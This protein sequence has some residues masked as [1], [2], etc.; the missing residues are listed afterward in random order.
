MEH[1]DS[2]SLAF[3]QRLFSVEEYHYLDVPKVGIFTAIDDFD[4]TFKC[5][6]NRSCFS[7]NLA[8][9]RESNG[10]L[11]CELLSLNKSRN[12]KYFD[13]NKSWHHFSMT[14]GSIL[15]HINILTIKPFPSCLLPLFQNESTYK[16]FY[17]K[18]SLIYMKMNG[19]V[20]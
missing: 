3:R 10:K 19:K 16:T 1:E 14:V 11:W 12:A 2:P 13:E 8:A 6:N 20:T 5:R 4:C 9:S 15:F 18:M 7:V 17:L